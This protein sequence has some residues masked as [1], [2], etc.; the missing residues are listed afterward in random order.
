MS[1]QQIGDTASVIAEWAELC[2]KLRSVVEPYIDQNID[3]TLLLESLALTMSWVVAQIDS[4][5]DGRVA[6][7]LETLPSKIMANAAEAQKAC[8]RAVQ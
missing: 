1:W 2:S 5:H 3:A 7:I 6:A 4:R 8:E